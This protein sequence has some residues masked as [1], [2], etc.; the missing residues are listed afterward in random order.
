V[1]TPSGDSKRKLEF[2]SVHSSNVA[3]STI[4]RPLSKDKG[5]M[6]TPSSAS[7]KAILDDDPLR[8]RFRRYLKTL[9][10]GENLQF[11]DCVHV[12][13][14]EPN[15]QKR[16]VSAKAIIQTFVLD[17][18]PYQVNL[19][20]NTKDELKKAHDENNFTKLADVEFFHQAMHELFNDLLYSD[21]FRSFMENDTFSRVDI[22][23]KDSKSDPTVLIF[24][25]S[26]N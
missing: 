4:P 16:A 7:L 23:E 18:S 3:I 14:A 5:S 21:A 25:P 17:S 15:A 22:A 26:S 11:Y 13:N 12:N 1:V 8:R 9:K 10:R 2:P 6:V 20:S 24:T 19:S